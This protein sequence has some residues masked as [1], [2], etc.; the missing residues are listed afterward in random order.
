MRQIHP[1]SLRNL[2]LADRHAV[3]EHLPFDFEE[4]T[5]NTIL[6]F[7]GVINHTG[8]TYGLYQYIIIVQVLSFLSIFHKQERGPCDWSHQSIPSGQWLECAFTLDCMLLD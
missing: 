8:F 5:V 3:M 7:G 2:L 4:Y 1:A 6:I